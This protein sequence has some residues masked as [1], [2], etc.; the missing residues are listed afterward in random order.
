MSADQNNS[1][2]DDEF[3]IGSVVKCLSMETTPRKHPKAW[4]VNVKVCQSQIKMKV[5]TGAETNTIP[6]KTWRKIAGKPQLTKSAVLLRAFGDTVIDQEGM[7]KVPIQ[8]GS[9]KVNSEVF[10]TKGKTVPIIGL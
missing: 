5:D 2:S 4:F 7:A 9:K 10:V 6:I 1:D 8:V 3:W